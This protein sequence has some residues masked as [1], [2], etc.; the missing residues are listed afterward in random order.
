MALG[1]PRTVTRVSTRTVTTEGRRVRRVADL[2]RSELCQLLS[3][4]LGD[5]E[6]AGLVVTDVSVSADLGV[7]RVGV[8]L[9]AEDA[10]DARR[11]G[12]IRALGRA[13][14]RL[15]RLL[16]PRLGL[17]RT[18]ELRFVYDRGQDAMLRVTELLDEIAKEP[19]SSEGEG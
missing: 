16:G 10:P 8:R 7:A 2:L 18:P 9:L 13:R 4:E 6:L 3:R 12:L 5:P 11:R 1:P 14:G 15:R 17:R 19:Q